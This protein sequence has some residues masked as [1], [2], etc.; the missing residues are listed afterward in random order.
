MNF[1]DDHAVIRFYQD[2]MRGDG[3]RDDDG[4]IYVDTR[5]GFTK[6]EN[7]ADE[8]EYDENNA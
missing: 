3:W 7:Y 8:I 4:I 2:F 1:A 6:A 5:N